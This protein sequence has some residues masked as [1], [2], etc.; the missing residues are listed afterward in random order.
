MSFFIFK[1]FFFNVFH[2]AFTDAAKK[3]LEDLSKKEKDDSWQSYTEKTP[4]WAGKPLGLDEFDV[5]LYYI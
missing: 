5:I 1:M 4:V 3:L 2:L